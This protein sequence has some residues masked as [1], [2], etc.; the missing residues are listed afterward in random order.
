MFFKVQFFKNV[1]LTFYKQ[2]NFAPNGAL[3][4]LYNQYFYHNVASPK[5]R[6]CSVRSII[7]VVVISLL[8]KIAP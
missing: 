6:S 5:L 2:Y 3:K 7:M 4:T 1:V 8:C